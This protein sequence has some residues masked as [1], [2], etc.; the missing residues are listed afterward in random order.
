MKLSIPIA[1]ALVSCA[2][3]AHASGLCERA[4]REHYPRGN[5]WALDVC[6]EVRGYA[7]VHDVR[8]SLAV[9]VASHESTFRPW[10][11]SSAG[12]VGPM[13]VK[14][15][16]YCPVF[17]GV[18]VCKSRAEYTEAGVSHL[19]YLL[20]RYDEFRALRCYNKGVGGCRDEEAGKGYART[21]QAIEGGIR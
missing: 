21:V 3:D 8:E 13:Q 2:V 5:E 20:G 11:I 10:G 12:C 17:L 15:H 19:A 7:K 14:T 9:A 16:Y 18:R 6:E 1:L 4:T